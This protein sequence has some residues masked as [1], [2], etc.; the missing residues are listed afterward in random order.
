MNKKSIVL[1]SALLAIGFVSQAEAASTEFRIFLKG[2]QASSVA[3]T[4]GSSGSGSTG[5]PPDPNGPTAFWFSNCNGAGATGPTTAGCQTSYQNTPPGTSFSVTNGIQH[6]TIP[7]TGS[8]LLEANGASG[9]LS[10]LCSTRGAPA[11]IRVN[12]TLSK[13]QVLDIVVGQVGGFGG[14]S[15]SGGG[16]S[17]IS[18]GGVPLVVAGGGG[19][20][21]QHSVGFN[22]TLTNSQGSGLGGQNAEA[23][24][25]YFG[26]APFFTGAGQA[27]AFVNGAT[28]SLGTAAGG[29]VPGGFGGGGGG[30]QSWGGAGGGYDGGNAGDGG[31]TS[32]WAPTAT[33][34]SGGLQGSGG[35]SFG[36]VFVGLN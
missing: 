12:M 3:S 25:G 6:W 27:K 15:G 11:G 30:G 31:G 33:F 4:G 18:S 24:A 22:A 17:I 16:A 10:N 26:D 35:L 13:G 34:V 28:G 20:C 2:I 1:I 36:S 7:T 8:Y 9:G 14:T 32:H 23:G 29:A 5:A 19:G 21:M